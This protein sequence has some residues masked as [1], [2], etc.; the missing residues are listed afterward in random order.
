M[1]LRS[2]LAFIG[3]IETLEFIDE[4]LNEESTIDDMVSSIDFIS[5]LETN[6]TYV[7]RCDTNGNSWV[8]IY[9]IQSR[10][11]HKFGH[12]VKCDI[13]YA[14][15]DSKTYIEVISTS[16]NFDSYLDTDPD[17]IKEMC[18]TY[19]LEFY[20]TDDEEDSYFEDEDEDSYY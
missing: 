13:I 20:G 2:S 6:D 18:D 12:S 11:D 7:Y 19:G 16:G 5:E 4:L 9:E 3:E 14:S 15:T 8:N 1:E 10:I 17:K